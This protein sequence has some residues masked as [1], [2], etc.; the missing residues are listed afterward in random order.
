M[1]PS[2]RMA[3][4][5]RDVA[6]TDLPVFF[7]Q[8]LHPV[9][10]QMAAFTSRD[11]ADHQ[12]FSALWGRVLSDPAFIKRTVL[13]GEDVAG[14]IVRFERFGLPEITYWLGRE[15]WGKGI[16]TN[17]LRQ[18]LPLVESRP[19]YARAAQDNHASL[20]VLEKCGFL[21]H[22]TEKSYAEAR[23]RKI[24]EVLLILPA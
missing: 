7:Q 2:A 5:L 4:R 9:A 10:N 1:T 20:R 17:A 21:P 12:A 19:L 23:K 13:Y 24:Q 16:A 8:Q 15:Y 14:Y 18:F 6:E 3:V 22:S 11:P